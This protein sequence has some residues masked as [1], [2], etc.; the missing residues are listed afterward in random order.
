MEELG[1]DK[2]GVKRGKCKLCQQCITYASPEGLLCTSCGHPPTQHERI[3]QYHLGTSSYAQ[4]VS[5]N[6]D[7]RQLPSKSKK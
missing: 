2:R 5:N 6:V 4:I 7:K 1:V 3:D